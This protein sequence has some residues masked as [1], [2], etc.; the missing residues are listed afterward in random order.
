MADEKSLANNWE[1][2]RELDL[3]K[4]RHW[5][6]LDKEVKR[7]MEI[8]QDPNQKWI[9]KEQKARAEGRYK[10]LDSR[11]IDYAKLYNAVKKMISQHEALVDLMAHLYAS[12]YNNVSYEGRQQRE[13][14]QGQADILQEIFTRIFKELE[15]LNLK[16]NPPKQ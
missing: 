2:A 8:L 16:L 7:A 10:I 3:W 14:M 6:T 1:C 11:N 13:M 9:D 12:W 5:D 15:P 4:E